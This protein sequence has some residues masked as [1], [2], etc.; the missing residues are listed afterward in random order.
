MDHKM[1]TANDFPREL[2]LAEIDQVNGAGSMDGA[3]LG[4][5]I[6]GLGFM[7]GPFTAGFGFAIGMGLLF[8]T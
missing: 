3:A 6:M 1:T 7:G 2:T 4:I 5:A 8:S